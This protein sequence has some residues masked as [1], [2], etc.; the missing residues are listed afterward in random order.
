MTE[1][2]PEL[3]D[4]WMNDGSNLVGIDDLIRKCQAN[5]KN[6]ATI[7]LERKIGQPV[8]FTQFGD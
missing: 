1:R 6:V 3:C 8:V 5:M 7:E 4:G 2:V